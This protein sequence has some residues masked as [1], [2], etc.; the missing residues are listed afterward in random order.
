M[1]DA[2]TNKLVVWRGEYN[3]RLHD[4]EE[5]QEHGSEEEIVRKVWRWI[6]VGTA[7]VFTRVIGPVDNIE[8]DN[9][10]TKDRVR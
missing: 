1:A 5:T 3:N 9:L 6:D 8:I 10:Q 7:R 2:L 4:K